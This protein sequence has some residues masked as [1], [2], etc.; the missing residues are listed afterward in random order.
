MEAA[1]LCSRFYIFT[2]LL[3]EP[4]MGSAQPESA[5]SLYSCKLSGSTGEKEP[6]DNRA[7]PACL[8][9]SCRNK[10]N[11]AQTCEI[12]ILVADDDGKVNGS[13][14]LTDGARP[15]PL[16]HNVLPVTHDSKPLSHC[17]P[18]KYMQIVVV[19]RGAKQKII[20]N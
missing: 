11:A 10:W 15:W 8:R 5:N 9:P 7:S 3:R 2:L 4:A 6:D 14:T 18:K 19:V 13:Q 20:S 1:G 16:I 17:Q 12:F